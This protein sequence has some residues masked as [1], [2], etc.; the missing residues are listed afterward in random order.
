MAI[1]KC[2]EC[3]KEYSENADKCPNCGNP[4]P[5]FQQKPN[6]EVIIKTEKG[7]W[8]YGRLTIGIISIV[9][10]ILVSF[11]SCAAGISNSLHDNG[12][13]SG[14]MGFALAIFLLIAGI[15]GIC[16]RNSKSKIGA[17]ITTVFYWL[18]A[19]FTIGSGET[20]GD[21]PVWGT[22]SFIFGIIFLISAIKTKKCNK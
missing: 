11:Q 5:N 12:A 21:L 10:F 2:Q 14:S 7:F 15:V 8:S 1:I 22:I 17:I 19:L 18:G 4:T 6:T 13:T 9:L 20:Y 3:E 16:T